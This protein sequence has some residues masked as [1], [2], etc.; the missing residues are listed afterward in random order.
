MIVVAGLGFALDL[1][2]SIRL[3][4]YRTDRTPLR[5]AGLRDVR[6]LRTFITAAGILFAIAIAIAASPRPEFASLAFGLGVIAWWV[7]HCLQLG[8]IWE[9]AQEIPDQRLA[10]WLKRAQL[11]L[12]AAFALGLPFAFCLGVVVR[13]AQRLQSILM[14]AIMYLLLPY[15]LTMFWASLRLAEQRRIA[16]GL[17][18][19]QVSDRE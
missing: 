11:L 9:I 12:I 6:T 3:S 10:T 8:Y 14:V 16:E 2:G 7:W 17:A 19:E 15:A 5:D 13:P 18:S 1:V 4:R